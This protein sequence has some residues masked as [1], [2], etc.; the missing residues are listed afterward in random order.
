MTET[1]EKYW[2]S[3]Y[4]ADETEVTKLLQSL[5]VIIGER[6]IDGNS[7]ELCDCAIPHDAFLELDKHFMRLLI[8]GTK[9]TEPCARFM[10]RGQ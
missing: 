9:W 10:D 8:W 5:G 2:I 3:F 4:A 7:V 1:D 6:K